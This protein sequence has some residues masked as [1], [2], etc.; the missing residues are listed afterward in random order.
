MRRATAV[1]GATA[2]LILGAC[3][4]EAQTP[5]GGGEER[6]IE[7]EALDS[8]AF[9]PDRVTVEAGETV[10]FV[11]TN[12]GVAVHEFILGP[13]SVQVAHEAASEEGAE[14]GGMQVEGQL[15][16]LELSSGATEEIEVT[17]EDPG[18]VL[19]GCHEPG[20]YD[21]GMVG[22]VVVK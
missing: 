2:A 20:H 14:H 5:Q 8:L 3:G 19:Y 4:G 6:V 10:R 9:Q 11:V 13:E 12:P 15:A 22:T 17:F 7:I 1:L 16:A 18:E 21:G